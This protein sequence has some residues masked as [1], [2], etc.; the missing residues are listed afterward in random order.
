[1]AE[2]LQGLK[3]TH[4]CGELTSSDI[5]KS[6]TVMGWVHRRRDLGGLIFIQVRDVSG[7]C[8]ILF[9]GEETD[10]ALFDKA[11]ELKL[12]YVVAISGVVAKRSGGN[13][14]L[15]MATGEI[16]IEA[17]ALKI[18]SLADTP[19][20]SI[21]DENAG[22]LLRLQ[23]RYLDLR[24]EQ[25]QQN[26][27]MRSKICSLCREYLEKRRF[28]EIETPF[29]GKSTPEG[30]RD[31]LVPSRVHEGSF[32]ALPQ[33]P[34]LYKQLLMIGGMDRY[35]QIARCFRD[36]DLRANRQPEF[37]QVDIE[38]SFVDNEE[39]IIELVEELIHELFSKLINYTL[40]KKLPRITYAESVS[41][42]GT[43]KP[44]LRFGMEITDINSAVQDSGFALFDNALKEGGA[45]CAIV[46]EKGEE[47]L[48]RKE[49]DKLA[50]FVKTYKAKN[51]VWLGVGNDA[52]RCS[53]SKAVSAQTLDNIIKTLSLKKGDTAL[54]IADNYDI[55]HTALGA[56]RCNIAQKLNLIDKN[57][58]KALWVFDF[59]LLEYNEE[60]KK[61]DAKHHPFTSP[62]E[63]DL[64]LL[65]TAPQKVRAKAYDIVING[66]EIGGGSM[67][68]YNRDL[69]RKMFEVVG[70][71]EKDITER[72]GFFVGAFNY[73]TPPHGGLALGL[74][75]LVMTMCKTDNI[76]EVIA[77]PKTQTAA[78]MMTKAPSEVDKRQLDELHI[79]NAKKE[80]D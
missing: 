66:D 30:A 27:I 58:F 61:Y 6:V 75:R 32:Y 12:E 79:T 33:S 72:F 23:Y 70:L 8:Q 38:M 9:K 44:D 60:E 69:Q 14:N 22:E 24:R 16:E 36:E 34:Q 73:G 42:F 46:V 63:E 55:A 47:K 52:L 19:P 31:Y 15:A 17:N 62:K 74:D 29:L 43:D 21:G 76:K 53:F 67:R 10:K 59:P 65:Y 51:L 39:Q 68:I 48:S 1:M 35:Y 11:S 56:L 13:A 3:R 4:Y 78:C 26:L 5:G 40:P 71:S 49:L 45:V 7:I 20:F 77:F 2:F 80:N 37:T 50:D 25:L 64:P 57:D 18:L 54:I 28:I 41:R